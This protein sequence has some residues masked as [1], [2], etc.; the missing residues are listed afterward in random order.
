MKALAG[1][2]NWAIFQAQIQDFELTQYLPHLWTAG[3]QEKPSPTEP[4]LWDLHDT[5]QQQYIWEESWWVSG[6][7][8]VTEAW[9]F[10]PDQRLIAMDIYK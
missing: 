5:G 4:E 7:D 3:V 1:F 8:S 2:T 6:I 10:Q 9:G